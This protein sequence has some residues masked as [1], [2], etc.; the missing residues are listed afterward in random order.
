MIKENK[1]NYAMNDL[2]WLTNDKLLNHFGESE[3]RCILA[4]GSRLENYNLVDRF[5]DYD[6]TVVFKKMPSYQTSIPSI[7][8]VN[9]TILIE[10]E[11]EKY[12]IQNFILDNHG[13]FYLYRLASAK[14]LW[15]EN[16]FAG[17]LKRI[18]VD[19][20]NESLKK[21][22]IIHCWKVQNITLMQTERKLRD[23]RK[24]SL[25]IA[26]NIFFLENGIDYFLFKQKNAQELMI[27][28]GKN[29]FLNDHQT[30]I[31][32]VLTLRV[33]IN[34]VFKFIDSVKNF[35]IRH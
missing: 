12:G 35:I 9:L 16:T 28:L 30:Y 22:I 14:T 11:I 13:V 20:L 10:D 3:I 2:F 5:S 21:Q 17:A 26:Q 18:P 1:Y 29:D 31:Q 32:D 25:R 7:Q 33:S 6:I 24:Y 19:L 8:E 23:I 4:Y 34:E 15:G 27:I